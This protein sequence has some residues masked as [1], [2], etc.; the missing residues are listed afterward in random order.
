[1]H[2]MPRPWGDPEAAIARVTEQIAE[3]QQRAVQAEQ[4]RV[5]IDALRERASSPRREVTVT[6]DASGRFTDLELTRDAMSLA[7]D[8]LAR[9]I[10]QTT[11]RAQRAAGERAIQIA[12]DT[13]GADS[14]AVEHLRGEVATRTPDRFGSDDEPIGYR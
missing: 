8:A 4:V 10:I 9:L 14:P 11:A 3:A 2:E 13:F 12:A 6:V 7:P 1:M 5:D